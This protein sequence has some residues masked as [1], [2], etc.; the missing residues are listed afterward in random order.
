MR[1]LVGL[2][3]DDRTKT[4][5]N[6]RDSVQRTIF[7]FEYTQIQAQPKLLQFIHVWSNKFFLRRRHNLSILFII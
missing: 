4:D 5:T 6:M 7:S 3:Q 2:I 1:F